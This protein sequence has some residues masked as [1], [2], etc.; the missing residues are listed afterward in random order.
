MAN[1]DKK[2]ADKAAKAKKTTASEKSVPKQKV[3][4]KKAVKKETPSQEKSTANAVQS[5]VSIKP[6]K[7]TMKV[8]EGAIYAT[9]RRKSSTAK[10]WLFKGKGLI[11]INSILA[12][13]Y[14]NSER[15]VE[16]LKVPLQILNLD[17]KYDIRIDVIGGGLS[18]Q[19]DAATLGIS[20][21]IQLINEDYKKDLRENGLLTQDSREKERKKYGK[22]GA[23][24]S[25]QYRKR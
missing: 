17:G 9:G 24:K 8:E 21:A 20:R 15:L 3:V 13:E 7:K 6:E 4:L 14:L 5:N 1:S 10:V 2:P 11:R 23:R 22:R 25:P 18:G 12:N 19:A 16:Q